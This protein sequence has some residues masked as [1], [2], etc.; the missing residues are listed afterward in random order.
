MTNTQSFLTRNLLLPDGVPID[1]QRARYIVKIHKADGL[2][3]M[4][5]SI[6]ANVKR[7]FTGENQDLV[8]PY[9]LVSFAGMT[10]SCISSN[11]TRIL[12]TSEL[13]STF[14]FII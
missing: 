6:L 9:V 11:V 2:P 3:K 14:P 13:N 7:A 5:Y 8:D 4:N 1:R 10:V 12:K